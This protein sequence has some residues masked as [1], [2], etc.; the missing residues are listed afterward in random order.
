MSQSVRPRTAVALSG[1]LLGTALLVPVV[2]ALPAGAQ[3]GGAKDKGKAGAALDS[4]AEAAVAWAVAQMVKG[5]GSKAKADPKQGDHVRGDDVDLTADMVIGAA[6]TKTAGDAGRR[7][8]NW[9]ERHA[10]AYLHPGGEKTVS[11]GATAKLALVMLIEKRNPRTFG[12][13]KKAGGEDLIELLLST[14]QEEDGRFQDTAAASGK[15]QAPRFA[16][17]LA[18]LALERAQSDQSVTGDKELLA[19]VNKALPK[20]VTYLADAPCLNSDS[21]SG[22]RRDPKTC[23]A[24][25][26]STAMAIQALMPAR[27]GGNVKAKAAVDAALAWLKE[28]Q[29][30]Y[31]SFNGA[32]GKESVGAT[33]AAA[34]ALKAGGA[35]KNAN[36][37]SRWLRR[38]QFACSAAVAADR[39]AVRPDGQADKGSLAATVRAI[40]GLAQNP[41]M[42]I[43]SS[44]SSDA[45][46]GI[47]CSRDDDSNG[48][49]G[50]PDP[51]GKPSRS[52][53][54]STTAP[55]S[56]PTSSVTASP[57]PSTS[58]TATT[59]GSS[60]GTGSGG[61]GTSSTGYGSSGST[62]STGST[63]SSGNLAATG[64]DRTVPLA[65][66]AGVLVAAGAGAVVFARRRR[67][68]RA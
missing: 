10:S 35:V 18:I 38:L 67:G 64:A 19:K 15:S 65:V 12:G 28:E 58:A 25:A 54:P 3:E 55:T 56:D 16:Q 66:G 11:A 4:P 27:Q 46:Y 45:P 7:A 51:S 13:E 5:E 6:A 9:L 42:T 22:Q 30:E 43:D 8:T 33:A 41:F 60:G 21:S 44:N 49:P 34:Q 61:T 17:S 2:G 29:G 23:T 26:E 57:S 53:S 47:R 31:G 59:D 20:A 36:R 40:P 48:T 1:A 52:P 68:D 32:D 14:Q 39:G 37:A 50:T 63:G 62:G 24:D